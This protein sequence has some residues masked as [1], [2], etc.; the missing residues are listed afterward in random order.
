MIKKILS[1][2]AVLA[3]AGYLVYSAVAMTDRH[4][5]IRICRG[6]DL[7]ISD[8]LDYGLIDGD[9]V[10]SLLQERGLDPVGLSLDRI[11]I[12]GIESVLL[13]HPLVGRAQCYKTAG[14]MLRINISGKVPLVRVLNNRGQ[15]FYVDSRG[16]IL[17]QHS[18]AVQLPVATGYID[19][20]F[21]SGDLLDVVNAIDR[22]EF[23]KAQV[24]Q[25]NVTREG[26]IE[27]VPR[28]GDHLLILGTA[29]DVED[30][31]KRLENFYHKGLDN[32]GWNKYRSI[33]VAYENQV[34]CK[35]RK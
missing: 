11:D 2:L 20:K 23:W 19:R 22:S 26:Q 27:L 29:Q 18:L 28:V 6:I 14:N 35:K 1:I 21:A 8:S 12:E 3:F 24:E 5:D 9:M 15:D 4:E 31:L 33:S 16:E 32:V 7:H 34:V 25:I 30:K 17:T 13:R 10:T